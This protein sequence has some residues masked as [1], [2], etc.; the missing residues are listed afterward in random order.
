MFQTQP[1]SH[2]AWIEQEECSSV[3]VERIF[4]TIPAATPCKSGGKK[5]A[6]FGDDM[7]G[8][9]ER[10]GT[11][12]EEEKEAV[13]PSLNSGR[14]DRRHV[15]RLHRHY[16]IPAKYEAEEESRDSREMGAGIAGWGWGGR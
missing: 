10:T 12:E 16:T 2:T 4:I 7:S 9:R 6:F 1:K 11:E 13:S 8:H 15:N 3:L 14:I 5:N